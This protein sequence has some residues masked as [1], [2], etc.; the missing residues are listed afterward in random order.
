MDPMDS[1]IC[2]ALQSLLLQTSWQSQVSVASWKLLYSRILCAP[3]Q[4]CDAIHHQHLHTNNTTRSCI[5]DK[6]NIV[7]DSLLD[8]Q[9]IGLQQLSLWKNLIIMV[10]FQLFDP[11]WA[12]SRKNV[13]PHHHSPHAHQHI[14]ISKGEITRLGHLLPHWS[15]AAHLHH[16]CRHGPLRVCHCHQDQVLEQGPGQ[17]GWGQPACGVQ[18]TQPMHKGEKNHTMPRSMVKRECRFLCRSLTGSLST[19]FLH[20][21]HWLVLHTGPIWN[22]LIL[23]SKVQDDTWSLPQPAHSQ[24]CVTYAQM[25]SFPIR[26]NI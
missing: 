7:I 11:I 10:F 18:G 6:V 26:S 23:D 15:V 20:A 3:R 25:V 14:R 17:C 2:T 4:I 8:L 24:M 1:A 9:S 12:G 5:V 19:C 21:L 13:P 22:S 16:I